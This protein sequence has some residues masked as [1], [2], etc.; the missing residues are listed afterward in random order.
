VTGKRNKTR[1]IDVSVYRG[2]ETLTSVP[3]YI[4]SDVL[5]W[6]D[7]GKAYKNFASHFCRLQWGIFCEYYD[8]ANGTTDATRPP[9]SELLGIE[10]SEGWQD[11]GFRRFRFHDLRHLHAVRW[12]K[13]G[14]S[15]YDLQDRLGHTSVK[16]TEVYT[17][18][19][20][21]LLTAD[22]V[23]RAKAYGHQQQQQ[24]AIAG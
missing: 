14:R 21:G 13:D 20:A 17:S 24:V 9:R 4:G 11:I 2:F 19:Q 5:F 1:T 7:D 22:E 18:P 8:K 12:L 10:D 15:I 3:A 16:T 23:R 6:H